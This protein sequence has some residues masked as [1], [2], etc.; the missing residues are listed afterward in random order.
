MKRRVL[1]ALCLSILFTLL[2][3]S[4]NSKTDNTGNTV[5]ETAT[6]RASFNTDDFEINIY[7]D[8]AVYKSTEAIKI[9]AT[10]EYIGSSDTVT[11]WHGEPYIIFS[12]TDGKDFNIYGNVLTIM[13]RTDLEKGTLY[14]FDYQKSGGWNASAPDAAYW[15]SFFEEKDLILPA[16]EYTVSVMGAFSLTDKVIG[17]ESGLI[18]DLK[19]TVE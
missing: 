19:I 6:N 14:H 3:S 16:G 12:I 9:R 7:S 5:P 4:C 15:E 2:L 1:A 18:C 8:K 17:S 11:I 13:A 10:L